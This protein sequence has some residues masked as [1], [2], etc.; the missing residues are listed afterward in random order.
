MTLRA[1]IF[2]VDGTLADTE[3]VHRQSFN[4]AFADA[5]FDWVWGTELYTQLLVATGGKARIRFY[6]EGLKPDILKRDD[7]DQLIASLHKQKTAYYVAAMKEGRVPL[8]AGVERLLREA[9]DDGLILAIAT[10]TT[11]INLQSL[12]ESTLGADALDWFDAIGAGDCVDNLKP[13]PDVYL[14]VLDRLNLDPNQCLAIEDSANGLKAAMAAG[15]PTLITS[16]PYTA[17]HDFSGAVAVLDGLGET[18]PG[19][20]QLRRW[21]AH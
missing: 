21:H 17:H 15:V 20:E 1:L 6:L 8:R 18:E 7:I 2:D 4:T 14:W 5:G 13:A 11:P 16:C 10:T 3:E 12:I 19:L 9:R